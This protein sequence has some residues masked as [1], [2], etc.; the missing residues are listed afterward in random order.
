MWYLTVSMANAVLRYVCYLSVP[1]FAKDIVFLLLCLL[2]VVQVAASTTSWL[3]FQ[4]SP[5]GCV[6]VYVCDLQTSTKRLSKSGL[7]CYATEKKNYIYTYIKPE[8]HNPFKNRIYKVFYVY[9]SVHHNIFYE[10]TN[11]CRYMQ[12]ILFHC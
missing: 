7:G 5:I 4:R 9:G 1:G 2:C 8:L 10:I 3:L 6:C 12:S 11:G